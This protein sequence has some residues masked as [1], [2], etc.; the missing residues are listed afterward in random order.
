MRYYFHLRHGNKCIDDADGLE[1]GDLEAV[2]AE[3]LAAIDEFRSDV[4]DEISIWTG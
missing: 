3:A 4:G 2:K 1:L